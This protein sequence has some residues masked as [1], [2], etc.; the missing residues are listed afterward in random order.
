MKNIDKVVIPMLK[1]GYCAPK[2]AG[3]AKATGEPSATIHYN[4]KRMEKDGVIKGY[5]ATFDYSKIDE[6]VC[7]YV[8]IN[9]AYDEDVNHEQVSKKLAGMP[10][11]ESVDIISG[12][13]DMLIK[14]RAK[15]LDE[16]YE[17]ENRALNNKEITKVMSMISL[18]QVKT[19]F[20]LQ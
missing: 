15:S 14:V 5:K 13:W 4:I 9:L 17:F 8:L 7:A 16:F 3:L 11:V 6:G 19:E 18:K 12:G 1:T 2:I 10:Q 20:I